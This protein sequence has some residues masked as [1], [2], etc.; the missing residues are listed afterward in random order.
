M[1]GV[2]ENQY[3]QVTPRK[4]L[5]SKQF[6]STTVGMS[7]T[8]ALNESGEVFSWGLDVVKDGKLASKVPVKMPLS[9]K[10]KK[11]SLGI[12]HAALVDHNG[13]VYTWGQEGDW[14]RGGGYLGHGDRTSVSYPK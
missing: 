5:K 1:M 13:Q 2:L 8:L 4:I 7:T 3:T 11:A 9:G 10:Y 12:N 6:T 14:L